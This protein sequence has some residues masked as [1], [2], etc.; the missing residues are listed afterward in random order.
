MVRSGQKPSLVR[1]N[2]QPASP[3]SCNGRACEVRNE[4]RLLASTCFSASSPPMP[5]PT[6]RQSIPTPRQCCC[7]TKAVGKCGCT[8][9]GIWSNRCSSRHRLARSKLLPSTPSRTAADQFSV[10]MYFDVRA[11]NR[12]EC[13]LV[14]INLTGC[15]LHTRKNCKRKLHAQSLSLATH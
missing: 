3:S 1:S 12:Y 9:P 14:G 11:S 4:S 5:A 15:Q 2:L 13:S 8:R 6:W 7:W 10:R